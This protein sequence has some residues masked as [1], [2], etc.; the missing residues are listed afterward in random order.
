MTS[1]TLNR[2]A[3]APGMTAARPR[4]AKAPTFVKWVTATD[5]KVIANLYFITSFMFFMV[6]GVLALLIRAELAQPGKQLVGESVY[7]QLFT[8]H[9]SVMMFLFAVPMGFGFANYLV[10]LQI[11]APDMAFPRLNALSYWLYLGGGLTMVSGFLSARGAANFGWTAYAPLSDAIHSPGTGSDL[12]IMGVLV[13]GVATVLTGVRSVAELEENE[14]MFRFPV[15]AA[16]WQD[17]KGEGLLPA[18]APVPGV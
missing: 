11:G 18:A 2:E 14:R 9:G 3:Q 17:L 15:P 4:L 6:G 5:H 7:N 12:W 8:M 1:A 13:T 16:L 10:P